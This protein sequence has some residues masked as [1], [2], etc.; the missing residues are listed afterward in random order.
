MCVRARVCESECGS[1][2]APVAG[3]PRGPWPREAWAGEK[4]LPPSPSLRGQLHA[5]RSASHVA[6]GVPRAPDHP[7][8]QHWESGAPRACFCCGRLG[9]RG[10]GR[11]GRPHANLGTCSQSVRR[12]SPR[13]SCRGLELQRA[14]ASPAL[15]RS[16]RRSSEADPAVPWRRR[17]ATRSPWCSE[18][19]LATRP[20]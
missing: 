4:Q 19:S 7:G 10:G 18:R 9:K 2:R 8:S 6:A 3:D 12:S 5:G 1:A 15:S 11:Q 14:K 13:E 20:G 17:A 16:P